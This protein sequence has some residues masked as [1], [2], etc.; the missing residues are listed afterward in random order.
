MGIGGADNNLADSWIFRPSPINVFEVIGAQVACVV[1]IAVDAVAAIIAAGAVLVG[2][3]VPRCVAGTLIAFFP[4]DQVGCR[5]GEDLIED[6][7]A[8]NT[9]IQDKG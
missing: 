7:M 9:T 3:D 6:R 1:A 5:I 8:V 4:G 2:K